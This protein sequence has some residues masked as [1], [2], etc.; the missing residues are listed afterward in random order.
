MLDYT[1]TLIGIG[2]KP[3][4]VDLKAPDGNAAR[5][6]AE[7]LF[8]GYVAIGVAPRWQEERTLNAAWNA[9]LEAAAAAV[10]AACA[11]GARH[12]DP[13]PRLIGET[14]EHVRVKDGVRVG[15]CHAAPIRRLKR[16]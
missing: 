14:W 3:C 11:G 8:P 15:I 1:I 2:V 10:C 13:Q 9:A 5:E 7:R 6:E 4:D 12:L 16:P